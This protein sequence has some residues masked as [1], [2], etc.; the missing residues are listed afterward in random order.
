M[1]NTAANVAAYRV[2]LHR[3][4]QGGPW[5]EAAAVAVLLDFEPIAGDERFGQYV[6][7]SGV[8]WASVLDENWSTGERFLIASAAGLWT[9]TAHGADVSAMSRLSDDFHRVWQAMI[10]AA[11]TG[12]TP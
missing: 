3:S 7:R 12:E 5:G 4:L 11:R 6:N 10:T 1:T 9:G 8:D 2:S